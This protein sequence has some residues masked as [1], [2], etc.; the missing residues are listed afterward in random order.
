MRTPLYDK[1]EFP[2]R[3][4]ESDK[5]YGGLSNK[6][7][8]YPGAKGDSTYSVRIAIPTQIFTLLDDVLKVSPEDIPAVFLYLEKDDKSYYF[9]LSMPYGDVDLWAYKR[10]PD[11]AKRS[12]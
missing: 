11:W 4:D 7:S 8:V 1:E 3:L 10:L 2:I 9:G 6:C 5:P 12:R